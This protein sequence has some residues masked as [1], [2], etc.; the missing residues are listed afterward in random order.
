MRGVHWLGLGLFW[1]YDMEATDYWI[2]FSMKSNKAENEK[3]ID[4]I[5][6]VVGKGLASQI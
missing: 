4:G 5:L 6:G 2:I 3:C 1:S